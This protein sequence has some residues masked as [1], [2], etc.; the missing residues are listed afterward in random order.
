MERIIE[1]L[2]LSRFRN[3]TH[4]ELHEVL[5]GI[6][7]EQDLVR[8]GLDKMSSFYRKAFSDEKVVLDLILSS[9]L[10]KGIIAR[11][12][13]RGKLFNGFVHAVRSSLN[14]YDDSCV[15]AAEQIAF[16]LKK[17]GNIRVK[18]MDAETAALDDLFRELETPANRAAIDTLELNRWIDQMR[19]VNDEFRTLMHERYSERAQ[20]P[21]TRMAQAR[22]ETDKWWKHIH[23][24]IEGLVA[25]DGIEPYQSLVN[26]INTV[27][28]R[29]RH[30]LA[31]Q[32]GSSNN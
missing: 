24:H 14:H 21:S 12:H 10:T 20:L 2:W 3:E 4:V 9:I 27:I 7:D 5:I 13:R 8:L 22:V 6:L 16:V 29:Y 26:K 11:D 17:Y 23:A 31:Q 32:K 30:I 1:P 15:Q 18:T 25:V 28:E 19:T